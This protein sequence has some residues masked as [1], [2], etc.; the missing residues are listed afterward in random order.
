[1]QHSQARPG[2]YLLAALPAC[3]RQSLLAGRAPIELVLKSVVAEAGEPIRHVF[4]P[5]SGYI[6]LIAAAD[7]HARIEVGLVGREGMLGASSI[8]GVDTSPLQGLVQ[9]AGSAWRIEA[10]TFRR[11]LRESPTLRSGLGRYVHVLLLQLAQSAGC[12][13]FHLVEARLARWLL[14]V[15]DRSGSDGFHMTQEF[16]A[17]MLGVRRA[18]VTNAASALQRRKLIR[19]RRGEMHV[20]DVRGL[21]AAACTCYATGRKSYASIFDS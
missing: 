19:Y 13:R 9:G 4:F 10:S 2:N 12:T 17:L 6:S 15:R 18:G 11:A 16:L 5:A 20:L 21:E 1:M 8:V 3:D 14:M 7:P